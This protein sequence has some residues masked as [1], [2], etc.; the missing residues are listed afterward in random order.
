MDAL[1]HWEPIEERGKVVTGEAWLSREAA[2][3]SMCW[4]LLGILDK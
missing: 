2:E 3:F 1:G 4:S